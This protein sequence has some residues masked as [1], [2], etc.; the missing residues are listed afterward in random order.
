MEP[1]QLTE[2]IGNHPIL[3][4]SAFA[5]LALLLFGELKQRLSKV[6]EI[7]PSEATRMLNHDDAVII[8]I[9]NDKDFKDGHIV[10]SVHAPEQN[11]KLE[12]YRGKPLIVCCRSGQRSA[13][14]CSKLQQEGFE[15]VYN[16]KGGI[17][18]WQQ[19]ELPLTRA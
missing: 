17:H 13:S 9:R 7:G 3:T 11:M 18:A 6:R 16:L 1:G 8:D 19:A 5:L 14:L 2:F 15:S 4:G 10:N 12:K